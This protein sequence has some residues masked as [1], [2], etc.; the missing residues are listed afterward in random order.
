MNPKAV[1]RH[2]VRSGIVATL[3]ANLPLQSIITVGDALLAS[4]VLSVQIPWHESAKPLIKDLKNRAE[5]NMVVGVSEVET[6]VQLQTAIDSGVHFVITTRYERD[7]VKQ[8]QEAGVLCIPTVISIMA[9]NAAYQNGIRM[10]NM[11]TGGPQGATFVGMVV[12]SIP[13]LMVAAGGDYTIEDATQYAKSGASAMIV[14][15]AIF[16]GN[17]Q[18]MAD[19]ITRARALQK[20][21]DNGLQQRSKSPYSHHNPSRPSL[22]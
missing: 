2:I 18:T 22:N 19:I 14:Q 1:L 16:E 21:W 11:Q 15:Q 17:E 5:A 6:A 4:P 9:A 20:A 13:G 7:L 10:I 8:C 3:P 12:E